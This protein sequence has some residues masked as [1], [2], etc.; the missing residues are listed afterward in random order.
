M[1]DMKFISI[2]LF[3]VTIFLMP[4]VL[5]SSNKGW[6]IQVDEKE[7][8]KVWVSKNGEITHGDN[9]SIRILEGDCEIGNTVTTFYSTKPIKSSKEVEG[10][11]IKAKFGEES[12]HVQVLFA[13][14]FIVGNSI[15]IDLGW[16]S[17]T[18][19]K[20]FFKDKP[21]VT[22]KLEHG[23]GFNLDEYFDVRQNAWQTEG[24]DEVLDKAVGICKGF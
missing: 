3:L 23:E 12:I 9:L 16:N 22:L 6:E 1:L 5:I 4:S 24:I 13:P 19:I 7:T 8:S 17:V 18:A 2:K 20:N 11:F 15:W 10:Q 14:E 21:K